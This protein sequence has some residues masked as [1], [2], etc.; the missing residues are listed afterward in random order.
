[1]A[2]VLEIE[3]MASMAAALHII[4]QPDRLESWQS[5]DGSVLRLLL[6]DPQEDRRGTRWL[7][8]GGVGVG[9][10]QFNPEG[11]SASAG[12]GYWRMRMPGCKGRFLG[13]TSWLYLSC[14]LNAFSSSS[15]EVNGYLMSTCSL[16]TC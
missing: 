1:M 14:S 7:W 2:V 3:S 12:W 5:K 8:A 10:Y 4:V 11:T 6:C 15:A 9:L 13:E 16:G